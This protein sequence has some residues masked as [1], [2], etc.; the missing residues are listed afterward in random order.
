MKPTSIATLV[1][2]TLFAI[3]TACWIGAREPPTRKPYPKATP[4]PPASPI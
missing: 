4:P 3:G 1:I 2:A